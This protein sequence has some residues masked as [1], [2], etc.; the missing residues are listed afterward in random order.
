[1]CR[2]SDTSVVKECSLCGNTYVI[3]MIVSDYD[4]WKYNQLKGKLLSKEELPSMSLID[5]NKLVNKCC[6][7]C[8]EKIK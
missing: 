7:R 5:Y 3:K 6:Y 2:I 1:M 4:K 8:L